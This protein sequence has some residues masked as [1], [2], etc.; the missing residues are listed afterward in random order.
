MDFHTARDAYIFQMGAF[1]KDGSIKVRLRAR[2]ISSFILMVPFTEDLSKVQKN[3]VLES[4]FFI[5]ISNIQDLG[6][7]INLMGSKAYKSILMAVGILE[8]S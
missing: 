8:G 2:T 5:V 6:K 4:L 7:M 1:L 3:M